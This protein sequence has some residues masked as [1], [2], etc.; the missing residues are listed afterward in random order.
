M[1]ATAT[2]PWAARWPTGRPFL[3]PAPAALTRRTFS[4]RAT[5]ITSFARSAIRSRPDSRTTTSATSACGWTSDQAA[6]QKAKS[7]LVC[8]SASAPS[9]EPGVL[10]RTGGTF[11][12]QHTL[13]L[14]EKSHGAIHRLYRS[15]HHGPAHGPE[16]GQNRA[17]S[18]DVQPHPQQ[19][20]SPGEGRRHGGCEP[21]G[22]RAP[23]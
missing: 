17:Q 12:T 7:G 4:P 11:L 3:A 6:G 9:R 22:S 16:P 23:G 18:Y 2:A 19:G 14:E 8:L 20:R 13:T 5:P 10:R 15:R 21:G 1:V